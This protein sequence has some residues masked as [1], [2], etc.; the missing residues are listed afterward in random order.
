MTRLPLLASATAASLL[1]AGAA[2]A[3]AVSD[4][5]R[6]FLTKDVQGARYE[7]ALAQ[8]AQAKAAKVGFDWPTVDEVQA[9][10]REEI[11][12]V[13]AETTGGPGQNADAVA[14]EI[15]DLMFATVNLARWHRLDAEQTLNRATDKFVR[16]FR[17]IE[18]AL[19]A[20]GQRWEDATFTELDA[21]WEQVKKTPPSPLAE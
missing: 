3:A 12:E 2:S 16:R 14:D 10:V 19:R 13:E 20:R 1:V 18:D 21:L 7:L 15:G 4:S 11:A 5:D 8:T 17:R 6:A 9:K